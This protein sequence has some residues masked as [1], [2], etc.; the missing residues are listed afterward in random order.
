M[1]LSIIYLNNTRLIPCTEAN[2]EISQKTNDRKLNES[3]GIRI[4]S[5]ETLGTS[6]IATLV[7]PYLIE[8][9]ASM[10]YVNFNYGMGPLTVPDSETEGI[11]FDGNIKI[12]EED[13][14]TIEGKIFDIVKN[15]KHQKNAL[16]QFIFGRGL[17]PKETVDSILAGYNYKEIYNPLYAVRERKK[18]P[19][20]RLEL[21]G[22]PNPAADYNPVIR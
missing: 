9:S 16:A 11:L 13:G 21:H 18:N 15:G 14:E 3:S 10:D 1:R 7:S 19:L 20:S 2:G 22:F 4:I 12:S 6:S 5:R 17:S 8:A